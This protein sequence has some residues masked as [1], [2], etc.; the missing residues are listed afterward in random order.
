MGQKIHNQIYKIVKNKKIKT[1]TI[2][3]KNT[4]ICKI[5]HL[6]PMIFKKM[7]IFILLIQKINRTV[8][9]IKKYAAIL[10]QDKNQW[11]YHLKNQLNLKNYYISL[12]AIE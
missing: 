9:I 6:F 3:F 5:C 1:I 7:I 2:V 10:Q 4:K 12:I 11:K 8:I